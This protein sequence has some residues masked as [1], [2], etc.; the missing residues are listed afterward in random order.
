MRKSGI[1]HTGNLK[2]KFPEFCQRLQMWEPGIS[3]RR[4]KQAQHRKILQSCQVL[5]SDVCHVSGRKIE[6]FK[7][8][9]RREVFQLGVGYGRA[10]QVQSVETNGT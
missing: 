3:N 2:L 9:E 6:F 5:H 10:R 7:P 4:A 8:R 1:A